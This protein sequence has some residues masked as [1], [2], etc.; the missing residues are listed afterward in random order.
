MTRE[1]GRFGV[2]QIRMGDRANRSDWW[3]GSW[4]KGKDQDDSGVVVDGV[5]SCWGEAPDKG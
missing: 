5:T 4:G 2:H 3:A 1:T